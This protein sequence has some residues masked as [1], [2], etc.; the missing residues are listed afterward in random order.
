MDSLSYYYSLIFGSDTQTGST[1]AYVWLADQFGHIFIGFGGVFLLL[2]AVSLFTGRPL[3]SFRLK[4]AQTSD[5]PPLSDRLIWTVALLWLAGWVAKELYDQSLAGEQVALWLEGWSLDLTQDVAT[6]IAFYAIGVVLALAQLGV[7]FGLRPIGVFAA[8][9]IVAGALVSY[10]LP[11][12]DNL[13]KTNIPHLARISSVSLVP[14]APTEA[15]A[16]P[17]ARSLAPLPE[18]CVL[19]REQPGIHPMQCI[20]RGGCSK[21]HYIV[22]AL[23]EAELPPPPNPDPGPGADRPAL[24]AT[25]APGPKQDHL[26]AMLP[27]LRKLGIAMV[28]ERIFRKRSKEPNDIYFTTL[29]EVMRLDEKH[30]FLVLDNIERDITRYALSQTVDFDDKIP[31]LEALFRKEMGSIGTDL[32]T[33]SVIWLSLSENL[34]VALCRTLAS[35]SGPDGRIVL[36]RAARP[37]DKRRQK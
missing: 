30:P 10:W 3:P 22:Y 31:A 19:H 6:D 17:S 35:H 28:A 12:F 32:A 9:L 21:T 5:R 11:V 34:A 24:L 13:G 16:R 15:A 1:P 26:D 36:I 8:M 37:E 14:A 23:T 33:R 27:E 18:Q 2:W 7:L 4:S 20:A 25:A 29:Y